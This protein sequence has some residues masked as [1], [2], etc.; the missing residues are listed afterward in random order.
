MPF[1]EDWAHTFRALLPHVMDNLYA[2]PFFERWDPLVQS[3]PQGNAWSTRGYLE[4]YLNRLRG[5]RESNAIDNWVDNKI[6]FIEE[7]MGIAIADPH[8]ADRLATQAS[9]YIYRSTVGLAGDTA[10][11]NTMQTFNAWAESGNLSGAMKKFFA[12]PEAKKAYAEI[13]ALEKSGADIGIL[14]EMQHYMHQFQGDSFGGSTEGVGPEWFRKWDKALTFYTMKPMAWTENLNRG[15]TLVSALEAAK[16]QG[17]DFNHALLMGYSR[18]SRIHQ[19]LRLSEAAQ[20]A[21]L[22]VQKVQFGYGAASQAPYLQN[23]LV[24]L[25]TLFHSYPTKQ[26]QLISNNMGWEWNK[27]VRDHGMMAVFHPTGAFMRYTALAG[28]TVGI[29]M[30]LRAV[31]A[32][33]GSLGSF[34]PQLVGVTLKPIMLLYNMWQGHERVTGRQW[35]DATKNLVY[36]MGV[37]GQRYWHEKLG[38]HPLSAPV[39]KVFNPSE[40]DRGWLTNPEGI[41][42]SMQRGFTVNFKGQRMYD[43]DWSELT[44]LTGVTWGRAAEQRAFAREAFRMDAEWKEEQEYVLSRFLKT[45][46]E[47]LIMEFNEKWAPLHPE[48]ALTPDDI[49][50][51]LHSAQLP[52]VVRA[53]KPHQIIGVI[54]KTGKMP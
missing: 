42:A 20:K 49:A 53:M 52:Y 7:Q 39:Q 34:L 48:F 29:G 1:S 17:L 22:D 11:T 31:G 37:P 9:Q 54:N 13:K 6:R 24:K 4:R 30:A 35:A 33:P 32:E 16:K 25:L 43:T 40:L 38:F 27:M 14:H 19:P 23:P 28:L 45:Q 12:S 10:L 44:R 47:D 21:L 41:V 46:N 36:H 50:T 26:L 8:L 3:L 2:K 5:S 15:I 18:A 51:Y